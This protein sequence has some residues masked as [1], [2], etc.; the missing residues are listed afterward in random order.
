MAAH[1]LP[2]KTLEFL[3]DFSLSLVAVI[4][5]STFIVVK[6]A[7]E[8]VPVF[9]FL[10]LR[11]LLAGLLLVLP[12]APRLKRMNRHVLRDGL[13]LGTLLFLAFATQTLGLARTPA[14]T[15]AFIT[16]LYV[17]FV[18]ILASLILKKRTRRE[19]VIG[20]ILSTVGLALITLQGKFTLSSGELLVLLCAFL[21]GIHI[22]LIDR[23]SRRNDFALL[24]LVQV[25][26]VAILS[27]ASSLLVEPRTIPERLD[28]RLISALVVTSVFATVLAFGI[29]TGMQKYTT[30]TKAAI[31]FTLEPVSAAFF[32]YW[33]GGELLRPRQYLGALLILL[34]VIV[35]ETGSYRQP[36]GTGKSAPDVR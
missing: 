5:G 6:Q 31:L 15:T 28:P 35:S 10:F 34:A 23:Y 25:S 14:T 19:A 24:T 7:V 18:P 2:S 22:I 30:P 16:S 11:F 3:A 8:V 17:V 27:L 26:V 36:E 33:L 12:L 29:Q 21:Y 4:W 9:S 13:V 20:V 1:R 32:S